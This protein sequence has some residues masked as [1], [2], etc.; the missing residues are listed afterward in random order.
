MA[1]KITFNIEKRTKPNLIRVYNLYRSILCGY[2][3]PR[4]PNDLYALAPPLDQ[5]ETYDGPPCAGFWGAA[6]IFKLFGLV[7]RRQEAQNRSSPRHRT[8]SFVS[9]KGAQ[10]GS[11]IFCF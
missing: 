10:F 3:G 9:C 2:E 11:K 1:S 5:H 8:P 7:T 6:C 4:T